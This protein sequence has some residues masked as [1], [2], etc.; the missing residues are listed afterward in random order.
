MISPSS[1]AD[2]VS[3]SFEES[4]YGT[5]GVTIFANRT[6]LCVPSI[7]RPTA[8]VAAASADMGQVEL[9][10]MHARSVGFAAQLCACG[11]DPRRS[12]AGY[13]AFPAHTLLGGTIISEVE[14]SRC[15]NASAR[16]AL[17]DVSIGRPCAV[18][19]VPSRATRGKSEGTRA[20]VIKPFGRRRHAL[21]HSRARLTGL[22]SAYV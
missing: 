16:A 7:P 8:P 1:G 22:S 19:T 3:R 6:S 15:A 4:S 13:K 14:F 18:N 12:P 9:G 21:S 10:A 11:I 17:G 20:L 5:R 2:Q